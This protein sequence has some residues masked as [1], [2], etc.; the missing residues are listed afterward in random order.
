[1]IYDKKAKGHQL[2]LTK[3]CTGKGTDFHS[4]QSITDSIGDREHS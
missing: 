1:M 2:V 3:I 4:V